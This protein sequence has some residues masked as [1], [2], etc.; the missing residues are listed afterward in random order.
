MLESSI[1]ITFLSNLGK[2]FSLQFESSVIIQAFLNQ[3]DKEAISNG[4]IFTKIFNFIVNIFK[5]IF[6]F[7]KLDKL[8]DGSI[9][10]MPFLFA[11]IIVAVSPFFP[12]MVLVG[13]SLISLCVLF[14]WLFSKKENKLKFFTLNKYILV[15]SAVY[16]YAAFASVTML[17]SVKVALVTVSLLLFYFV[18]INSIDTKRKFNLCMFIFLAM[19]IIVSL[20]GIYQYI[21]PEKYSGVWLDTNMFEDIKFRAYSTFANPNVLGEYLLLTI[22]FAFAYIING[23]S[24]IT[25][26]IAFGTFCVMMLC[27]LLT[28]S[29][30]CYIGILLAFGVFLILWDKRF[31]WFAFIGL[32]LLPLV[33]PESIINRFTSIGNLEDSSTS[34]RVNIWLGTINMLKDYWICGTGPGIDAFNQVYPLYAY[35]TIAAPHSHNLFLQL[36]CDAGIIGVGT[37]VAIIYKFFRT[38]CSRL[39]IETNKE[40]RVFIIASI[41]AIIGFAVQSMF[42]YTFY[43]YKVVLIFWMTLGFG[44]VTTKLY[45]MK[46]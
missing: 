41:A 16:M 40:N 7:L 28:Y 22:P 38:T 15:F 26:F 1:I 6:V 39:K 42:D 45:A 12:T 27:L 11:I 17:S 18:I 14:V 25:K 24:L 5:S 9:F 10:T 29:R 32:L 19:G 4:S 36:M 34:Y 43:N 33:M 13:M 23:K 8:L 44:I 37:F 46:E 35:N 21:F 2:S 30:G 31:V 3:K 20:Y